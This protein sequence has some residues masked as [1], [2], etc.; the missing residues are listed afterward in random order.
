MKRII[1][2]LFLFTTLLISCRQ[3]KEKPGSETGPQK[4]MISE[5]VIN[6]A[7]DSLI[8]L[9]GEDQ[10]FRIERGVQQSA[11]FWQEQD[12]SAAD[13]TAF[14]K[15]HFVA[16]EDMLEKLFLRLSGNFEVLWGS[17]NKI[18]LKVKEPL[19]LEIGE[20]LPVDRIFGS[21]S[22]GAHITD[23][24][25]G[26]KIAFITLL[27][28]PFYTLD[29][30]AALGPGWSRLQWAYARMG[31][32]F[33]SRSPAAL[34][35]QYSD[36]N[37]AADAYI[38]N[39]NIYMGKLRD[40]DGRQLFPDD[41]RLITH[42]GLR[43]EL[44]SNY[45][46]EMG[47]D[48]QRMIYQVMLHIINQDIPAQVI[49][50]PDVQWNPLS[51]KVLD[52][53]QW[54]DAPREEDVRYAH[55]LANF[56]ALHALDQYNPLF[57]DYISRKF[58]QGMEIPQAEVESLFV[59]LISDPLIKETAEFI[60]ERLGR[61]LEPFDIW[62][63]GFKA[64]S[65]INEE[66][67]NKITR[68]R[69][70][71]KEAF[72]NDLPNIL[73]KL[74]FPKDEAIDITSKISVDP[75]RG[76]GHA[77]GAEM[78]SEKSRLRTRI[79][80]QGMDYKGYNIAVHEFGHNVEQTISLH[81]VDYYMLN[82][83]PNTSF[84]EALAF[85]FQKKDLELLGIRHNDPTYESLTVLDHL[86][87]DYEIMGVSLVDMRVW[88]WLYAH[89]DASPLELR[90][91]L[92]GIAREVWNSYYA[93]VFGVK[94]S[95]ILAIY[96]HMIDYPLYLPAY[97]LGELIQFQVENYLSTHSFA[98]EVKRM[99]SIGRLIPKVW[100][101]EAVGSGIS[102]EPLLDRAGEALAGLKK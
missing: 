10:R 35:Q 53:S 88:K 39:Y 33:T 73:T 27:N 82:G 30:K 31:E 89:P 92:V 51:N 15:E 86:W 95:P 9:Y 43:D 81:N 16:D 12:G 96:S 23:D 52:G 7:T 49:N 69:Y 58:D 44:K 70:P 67:L 17:M 90:E 71:N 21:F 87:S 32:V 36:A 29:E 19:D 5:T 11:S 76:A 45:K 97:P 50:N 64:R 25:F 28:F 46:G 80:P 78:R 62:Y 74:G 83:V 34:I 72:E 66:E 41:L 102:V 40:G 84:T 14:C 8:A 42:W 6:A 77:W 60:S 22:P 75:S 24:L 65:S 20:I 101:Q 37:T 54:K 38:S 98:P 100:M 26:N 13:F 57:P 61:P 1:I 48:K 94:D 56:K 63:D 2:F 91:A 18:T 55:L 68:G 99:Y 79:G 59:T 85:V 4:S 3:A 93:P 47:L